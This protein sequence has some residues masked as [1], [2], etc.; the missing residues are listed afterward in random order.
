ML[1]IGWSEL[2]V[3]AIVLIVVVGPKDLPRMLRTF[4]RFSKQMRSMAGDFRRQF[5]DAL[6]EA[7]LDDVRSTIDDVRRHDPSKDIRTA[8]NPM[9][10]IGEE[11]RSSLKS[12]TEAP[13][14]KVAQPDAAGYSEEPS[15][16]GPAQAPTANSL[17]SVDRS[18]ISSGEESEPLKKDVSANSS[19]TEVRKAEDA[20]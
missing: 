1:E 16:V 6:R 13:A 10:A 17:G 20:A 2:L 7:E 5:D 12:A 15:K 14:P 4:G 19:A 9:R 11:I 18:T 8:L 3:I